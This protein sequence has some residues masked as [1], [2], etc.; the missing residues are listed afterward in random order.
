[1]ISWFSSQ[2]FPNILISYNFQRKLTSFSYFNSNMKI[3]FSP[4][5]LIKQQNLSMQQ[6]LTC[7]NAVEPQKQ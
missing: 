4:F 7:G 1:M 5:Q 3:E 2:K 6:H